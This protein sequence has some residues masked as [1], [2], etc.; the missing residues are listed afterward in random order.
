MKTPVEIR[1]IKWDSHVRILEEEDRKNITS[2]HSIRSGVLLAN[3]SI[4]KVKKILIKVHN[5]RYYEY[6]LI[7]NVHP[8]VGLNIQVHQIMLPE[9]KQ[10]WLAKQR[11]KNVP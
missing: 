10:A 7:A 8:N 4:R 1:G 5:L 11:Q 3:L 9:E 6:E 2:R